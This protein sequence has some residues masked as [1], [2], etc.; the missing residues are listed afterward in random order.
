MKLS[1]SYNLDNLDVK[2]R[3]DGNRS[4]KSKRKHRRDSG[5]DSDSEASVFRTDTGASSDSS[6]AESSTDYNSS[7]SKSEEERRQER[8]KKQRGRHS[9]RYIAHLR[10]LL[11]R[12]PLIGANGGRVEGIDIQPVRCWMPVIEPSEITP[13]MSSFLFPMFTSDNSSQ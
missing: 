10:S 3:N 7:S 4:K 8:R 13:Y 9:R 5:S 1:I 2:D 6:S 12:I 11:I